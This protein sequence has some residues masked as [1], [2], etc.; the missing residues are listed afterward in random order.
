MI[1]K[2]IATVLVNHQFNIMKNT[3]PQYHFFC[4]QSEESFS[5]IVLIDDIKYPKKTDALLL[6]SIKES[7]EKT[8][9]LRGYKKVDILFVIFTNNPF[10][11]KSMADGD[12][13]FWLSDMNDFR[14]ISYSAD[15]GQ[16]AD[17][18]DELEEALVKAPEKTSFISRIKHINGMSYPIF[19]I[20]FALI[21]IVL[22]VG[23]ELF[24]DIND[25]IYIYSQGASEWHSVLENQ[26][27]YRLFTCMFI[28]FSFSHLASNMMSLL[29]I[30]HQLEPAIGHI[31]FIAIYMISGLCSSLASVF[32]HAHMDESAISAGASGAIFGIFGAYAIFALF[33]KL[34]GRPVPAMRIALMSILVLASGFNSTSIDNAAHLGGIISGCIIAFICC[35]C[36][37]NKI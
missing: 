16:F 13:T 3:N 5:T 37:K 25:V 17:I 4:K 7:L 33:D 6:S 20:L 15:D 24:G 19:A 2:N 28:H 30:G 18:R 11:Y 31:K 10:E 29:A 21:N 27:Y 1:A 8:F 34:K 14:I 23:V 35:I 32:Y 36:S 22:Y 9:F 26:E 12:F